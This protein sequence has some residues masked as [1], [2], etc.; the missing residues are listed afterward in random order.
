MIH[1]P[2]A[3]TGILSGMEGRFGGISVMPLLP[4]SGRAAS[5]II[6][7][8][9]K[10]SRAPLRLLDGL[11]LHEPGGGYTRQADAMLRDGQALELSA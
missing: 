11:V 5:R 4:A 9:I 10:G 1:R 3:L 7:Q 2:E 6:V 8:G